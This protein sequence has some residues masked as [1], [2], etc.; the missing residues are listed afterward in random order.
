MDTSISQTIQ[1]DVIGGHLDTQVKDEIRK[2]IRQD[3]HSSDRHNSER[4]KKHEYHHLEDDELINSLVSDFD[5]SQSRYINSWSRRDPRTQ[6]RS[7]SRSQKID[8]KS[9]RKDGQSYKLDNDKSSRNSSRIASKES[10]GKPNKSNKSNKSD[11]QALQDR[12]LHSKSE[13]IAATEKESGKESG[14]EPGKESGKGSLNHHRQIRDDDQSDEII[15][16]LKGRSSHNSLSPNVYADYYEGSE[17]ESRFSQLPYSESH[18]QSTLHHIH[19]GSKPRP[20]IPGS[21][22]SQNN[23]LQPKSSDKSP[24][25]PSKESDPRSKFNSNDVNVTGARAKESQLKW[26]KPVS[27]KILNEWWQD[28]QVDRIAINLGACYENYLTQDSKQAWIYQ[29]FYGWALKDSDW[30]RAENYFTLSGMG[31]QHPEAY[32]ELSYHYRNVEQYSVAYVFVKLAFDAIEYIRKQPDRNTLTLWPAVHEYLIDYEMSIIGFYL[33]TKQINEAKN[34]YNRLLAILNKVSPDIQGSVIGNLEYY[35]PSL[36]LCL[37]QENS[38]IKF[39]FQDHGWIFSNQSKKLS[40]ESQP[41]AYHFKD[42]LTEDK[43]W[44]VPMGKFLFLI[45]LRHQVGLELSDLSS[46]E[47]DSKHNYRVVCLDR[48]DLQASAQITETIK[49]L[50]PLRVDNQDGFYLV[51]SKPLVESW[52][53]E[54]VEHRGV[55]E[56][57]RLHYFRFLPTRNFKTQIVKQSK[58]HRLIEMKPNTSIVENDGAIVSS[59]VLDATQSST[60]VYFVSNLIFDVDPQ[61]TSTGG[62]RRIDRVAGNHQRNYLADDIDREEAIKILS[63]Y[64]GVQLFY[65]D[66]SFTSNLLIAYGQM[67]DLEYVLANEKTFLAQE[68]RLQQLVNYNQTTIIKFSLEGIKKFIHLLVSA[69]YQSDQ[70]KRSYKNLFE[71]LQE[72]Q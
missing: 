13:A 57:V 46:E 69:T 65:E 33:E 58:W 49:D 55:I 14:K 32:Y 29:Y 2:S 60:S 43:Y 64:R 28:D 47:P 34:S 10:H 62:I 26:K 63:I 8:S 30:N 56:A 51:E 37:D 59:L 50:R 52:S 15:P 21:S 68:Q 70:Y 48:I 25:A 5:E 42:I 66:E 12:L 9:P 16:K 18:T 38:K 6:S 44:P 67:S 3:L 4:S 19:D 41:S 20:R 1:V 54:N 22:G 45:S 23:Q 40:R 27:L 11:R 17:S 71:I 24:E 31:G 53:G 7:Q 36:Q 72:L 35:Y 61:Q 39:S